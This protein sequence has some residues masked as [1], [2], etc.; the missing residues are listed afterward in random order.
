VFYV[1]SSRFPDLMAEDLLARIGNQ[2]DDPDDF[3]ES[4]R[5]TFTHEGELVCPPKDFSI[6]ALQYNVDMLEEAGVAPPTTWDELAAAAEAL[7]DGDRVG[8]V[9]QAELAR[10]GVFIHGAGGSVLTDDDA[11]NI[12]S[13]V[14]SQ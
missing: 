13:P 8:L 3:Y 7:T 1:D 5:E 14:D 4:L 6:L 2:L 9:M 10:L 12:T 11:S